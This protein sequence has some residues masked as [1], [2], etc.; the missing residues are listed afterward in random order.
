MVG[1]N[2]GYLKEG[3]PAK[4]MFYEGKALSMELPATVELEVTDT[5]PSIK[6]ATASAQY[7]PATL[8]TG[9]K[10]NVPSFIG[11]GE[12]ILVDTRDGKYMSRVKS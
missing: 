9:I 3:N 12:K 6:G 5:E 10:I 8:D 1:D 11:I 7:K 4:V 2:A